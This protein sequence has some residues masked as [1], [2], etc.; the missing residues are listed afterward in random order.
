[1]TIKFSITAHNHTVVTQEVID[2]VDAYTYIR[3]KVKIM[4][5][6]RLDFVG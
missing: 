2:T 3:Q 1:M 4:A 6:N 5:C